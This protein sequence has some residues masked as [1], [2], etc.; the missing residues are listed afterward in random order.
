MVP[1]TD[2][3]T[4]LF[5]IQIYKSFTIR[6]RDFGFSLLKYCLSNLDLEKNILGSG[7]RTRGSEIIEKLIFRDF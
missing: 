7:V 4:K 6:A 5:N 2:Q 1:E 3:A